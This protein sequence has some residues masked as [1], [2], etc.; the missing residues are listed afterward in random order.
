MHPVSSKL[1]KWYD[2]NKRSMP[3]RDNVTPYRSLVSEFMLQQT[4]VKTV[5]PYFKKFINRFPNVE[6]LANADIEEVLQYWKGLGYYRRAHNLHKSA[7]EIVQ[8]GEFPDTIPKL[9]ALP[10]VGEYVAGAIGSIALNIDTPAVDGNLHRVLS[11]VFVDSGSR[12]AIWALA[13]KIVPSGRAGDFNQAL[14]DLGA[15]LCSAKSPRCVQCPINQDCKAYLT[16]SVALYP[17]PKPKKTIPTKLVYAVWLHD[18]HKKTLVC[19]NPNKGLFSGLFELPSFFVDSEDA[20]IASFKKEFL[21]DL[22]IKKNLGNVEHRLTHMLLKVTLLEV[23][24]D[25]MPTQVHQYQSLRYVLSQ[26]EVPLSTLAKKVFQLRE[27][28]QQL[29]LFDT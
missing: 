15:S 25:V 8:L 6:T 4:Q 26:D 20:L 19:Q 13:W 12:K 5:I 9:L 28:S 27:Q 29:K 21:C 14:M 24:C 23:H 7:K 2:V 17:P 22:T 18:L 11:R 16:S 1:L 10:G 3:W